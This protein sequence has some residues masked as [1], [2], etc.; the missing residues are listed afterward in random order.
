MTPWTRRIARYARPELGSL[1]ALSGLALLGAGLS[2]LAPWPLKL[3]VDHVLPGK[4]L[5]AAAAWLEGLPGFTGQSGA[6]AWLAGGTILVFLANGGLSNVSR[7]LEAGLGARMSYALGEALFA[8]LQRLSPRELR[9]FRTGDLIRRVSVDSNCVRDLV[10]G[11]LAPALTSLAVFAAMFL[12]MWNLDPALTVVCSLVVIPLMIAIRRNQARIAER[13]YVQQ[14]LEGRIMSLAEQSLGALPVVQAFAQEAAEEGRFHAVSAETIRACL[15]TVASQLRFRISVSATTTAASALIMGFGGWRVL[16]DELTVGGL[17]VFLAYLAALYGPLENLS[18]LSE[19]FAAAAGRARRVLEVLDC[20][21]AIQDAPQG[22]PRLSVPRQGRGCLR[23]EGVSFGYQPGRPVL[24]EVTIEVRPGEMIAVVGVSGAGKST[25]ACL[26]ARL[27]DPAE[28]CICLDGRD[29]RS[30][31]LADWRRAVAV[32]FQ[33]PF[34]LPV[35]IAQNI[36]YGRPGARRREIVAA[37]RA[38]GADAFVSRMPRGYDTVIGER[39]AELSGGERQRLA[40]ARALLKDAPIVVLDEPTSALDVATEAQVLTSLDG[41]AA[42]RTT[43]LIT[44]RL[45][46]VRFADRI[47]LLSQGR[48]A[49]Q[50]SLE[51]LMAARGPYYRLHSQQFAGAALSRAAS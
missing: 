29:I 9:P 30:F 44:H 20:S 38:A 14:E 47:V 16:Q 6:L 50:G 21:P 17:L 25:L 43:I 46:T 10:T 2:A 18:L 41:L 11:V 23:I 45:S 42:G 7:Y 4:Q 15:R 1:T 26:I 19:H 48:V 49:E 28:G 36:A 34:L 51:Q 13:T 33:E 22:W 24:R 27:L 8:H 12:V 3:I 31:P 35:T 32:V 39:G 40:I 37:A 5:P